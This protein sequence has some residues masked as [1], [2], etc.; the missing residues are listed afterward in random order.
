MMQPTAEAM[1][2]W[3]YRYRHGGLLTLENQVRSDK[4]RQNIC[5]SIAEAM[6]QLRADHPRWTIATML[7]HLLEAQLWNGRKP[8]ESSLYRF[9]VSH[10]LQRDPH[11]SKTDA[12]TA[13]FA[14]D[15]FGQMWIAD[16]LHRPKIRHGRY[17]RKT[18][19]HMFI[20]DASRWAV[21]GGFGF[22]ET[23]EVLIDGL[24]Q[25]VGRFGIPARFYVDNGPC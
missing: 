16:F 4:G 19:L 17:Q 8:S 20:D 11:L 5:Q 21:E 12:A 23:V 7:Q 14:Y 3:L 13:P 22:G 18:L 25:A 2:K 9:A 6:H 1:R 15:A 24:M 10:N